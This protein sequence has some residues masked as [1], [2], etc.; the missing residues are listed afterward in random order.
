MPKLPSDLL[1][2]FSVDSLRESQGSDRLT[3]W[4]NSLSFWKDE[5]ILRQFFGVGGFGL[6]SI[7]HT[8]HNQFL[9]MLLDFG[10]VGLILYLVLIIN[11]A[12]QMCRNH[13]EYLGAFVGMLIL[14]MTLTLGP[15]YK[16]F[17]IMLMMVL[18]CSANKG[19]Q[20]E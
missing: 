19:A 14:S 17:W 20:N 1:M 8:M 3:I 18:V 9:Q 15:S 4:V 7:R 11:I 10:I 2:R 5:G 12:I 13:R 6:V 16:P